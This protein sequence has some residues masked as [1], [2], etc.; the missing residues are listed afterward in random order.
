MYYKD[1]TGWGSGPW[2]TEPDE[3][4]WV[5]PVTSLVCLLRRN[6]GGAWCGYVG[7]PTDHP[8]HGVDYNDIPSAPVHGGVTYM[9]GIDESDLWFVGFDCTHSGDLAPDPRFQTS[10]R[11]GVYRDEAYATAQ[12]VGLAQWLKAHWAD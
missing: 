4:K 8:W 5:D 12:V 1:R 3:T 11:N 6:N 2:D 9:D 10:W 7:L